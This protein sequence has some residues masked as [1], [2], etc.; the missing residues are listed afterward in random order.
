MA[1]I[2][3][4]R[5]FG[6]HGD[7]VA[8]LLSERLGYRYFDKNL[9]TG[10]AVQSGLPSE[11]L[12][13]LYEEKPRARSLV[14]RLFSN[15]ASSLSDPTIWA[16]SAEAEAQEKLMVARIRQLMCAAYQQGNVVIIGRGGQAA[17]RGRPGVLHVRVVAPLELRIRRHAERAG[18][19]LEDARAAVAQRD[20]ASLDYVRHF[21]NLD[22]TDP[23]L[24]DLVVNT[25]KMTPAAAVD[26]I[27]KAV[28]HLPA[29]QPAEPC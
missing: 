20:R 4:S 13:D 29:H 11:D 15:F 25:G 8:Q 1:T 16:A 19:S 26:L 7:T 14:E 17:L 18:L 21:Y 22:A 3:I 2:T 9:M 24:Y 28:D 5:Q 10:L 23:E 6:S 27:I 12:V